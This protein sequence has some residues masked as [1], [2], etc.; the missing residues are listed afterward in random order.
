MYR[1][2]M[3][4]RAIPTPELLSGYYD[5]EKFLEF[6]RACPSYGLLWSCPP[7]AAETEQSLSRYRNAVVVG[8]KIVYDAQT[9]ACTDTK[10]KVI[11]CSDRSLLVVK[12]ELLE[13]LLQLEKRLPGSLAISSGGCEICGRCTRP[14][15]KPC[16]HPDRMRHSFESLGVDLGKL[17]RDLL[18]IE[19]KWSS[20]RLPEYF[21]L[22]CALLTNADPGAAQTFVREALVED[23]PAFS[24]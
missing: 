5:R 19:L 8:A 4:V 23:D 16:R 17:A 20:G 6:C 7:L 22:I 2:E 18:G 3:I 24:G 21:T 9:V 15:I 12:K 10:E 13:I 11:E 1:T 14:D